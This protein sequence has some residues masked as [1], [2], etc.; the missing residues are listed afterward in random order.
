M[1]Y[2][3]YGSNCN[4]AVMEKKGVRFSS[5]QHAVLPGYR[6]LFNKKAMRENLPPDIGFANINE[7]PTG[8]VEGILYD[9]VDDHLALLDE[10]ERYPDHYTRIAITVQTKDKLVPCTTY[11]ALPDKIASGLKPS[12]N[13]LNHILSAKDFLSRQYFEALNKSQTY[14]GECAC[15]LRKQEVVFIK[16][17][18]RLHML[19]QPCREARLMWGETRGRRLTVA[20]TEAIMQQLVKGSSGFPSIQKLIE[21]AIAA[22]IIDP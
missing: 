13:Y 17:E 3:A 22:K 21:E 7:D 12:R 8:T 1:K 20:E 16:E 2:F 11:Q 15:C 10:S 19:C 18:D 4:H 14:L 6:L 5:C 9:I